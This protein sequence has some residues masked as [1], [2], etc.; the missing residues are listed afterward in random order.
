MTQKDISVSFELTPA[1]SVEVYKDLAD[2]TTTDDL[3]TITLNLAPYKNIQVLNTGST[4][5]ALRLNNRSGGIK[6]PAGTIFTIEDDEISNF[7]ILNLS[8]LAA[9]EVGVFLDSSDTVKSLLKNILTA[10]TNGKK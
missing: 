10:L 3:G 1:A 6:I 4:D 7:S 5:V 9:A 8:A 2:P